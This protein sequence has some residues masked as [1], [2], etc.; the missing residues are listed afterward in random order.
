[1]SAHKVININMENGRKI[2][3]LKVKGGYVRPRGSI[4]CNMFLSTGI[5]WSVEDGF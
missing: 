3:G 2:R 4:V 1:M 5:Q